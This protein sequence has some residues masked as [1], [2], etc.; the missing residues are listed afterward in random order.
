MTGYAGLAGLAGMRKRISEFLTTYVQLASA[1]ATQVGLDPAVAAAM[2]QT[3]GQWDGSG[4][5]GRLRA[6]QI[7]LPARLTHLAGPVEVFGR[8]SGQAAR[9]VWP[10]VAT[11]ASTTA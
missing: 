10:P 2:R 7:G 4:L 3:Y 11:A 5:P 1:F 9:S 6:E 8:R